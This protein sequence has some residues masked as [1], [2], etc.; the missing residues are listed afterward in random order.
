MAPK[1]TPESRKTPPQQKTF[2]GSP[3]AGLKGLTACARQAEPDRD[4]GTDKTG[5]KTSRVEDDSDCFTSEMDVLGVQPLPG[6]D[7]ETT[8]AD[9]EL[10]TSESP[11]PAADEHRLFLDALGT[12]D[13]IFRD[14]D[15]DEEPNPP[16]GGTVSARRMRQLGRG[17]VRP[18][19]ELDLHGLTVAAAS[20][21]V[22]FFL[23]DAVHHGFGCVLLITGKGLHSEDGPVLRRAMERL[24]TER[25][26]LVLE[27]GLA[28]QRL[29]G[30]GALAVFLRTKGSSPFAR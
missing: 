30:K 12:M 8:R 19:A 26:E 27:W 15:S 17:R 11:G 29:G 13:T 21:R 1:K 23:E 24:L 28:P 7:N 2:S 25:R 16:Q 22:G 10:P 14:M 3:F 5:T 4:P 6:R 18:E 20:A 9:E